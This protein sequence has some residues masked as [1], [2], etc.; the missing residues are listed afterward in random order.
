MPA[1]FKH[2]MVE[3]E[4]YGFPYQDLPEPESIETILAGKRYDGMFPPMEQM[5]DIERAAL[6]CIKAAGRIDLDAPLDRQGIEDLDISLEEFLAPLDLPAETYDFVVNV[7]SEMTF[8]YP[9]EP[10]AIVALRFS[11]SST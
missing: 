4:R 3:I 8:M 7:A 1:A 9:D 11:L 6:H 5:F 2:L 10:S